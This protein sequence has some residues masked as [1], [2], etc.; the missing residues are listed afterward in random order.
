MLNTFQKKKNESNITKINGIYK[1]KQ[2]LRSQ[3]LL[4]ET[5][6]LH[7]N[8][9]HIGLVYPDSCRPRTDTNFSCKQKYHRLQINTNHIMDTILYLESHEILLS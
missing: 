2:N 1:Y 7:Q 8:D 6:R 3:R 9:D 5:H 4:K